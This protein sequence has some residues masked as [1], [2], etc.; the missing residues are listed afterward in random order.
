[1]SDAGKPSQ[2]IIAS[3]DIYPT[4]LEL[5]KL[6][7]PEHLDGRS[8]AAQISEPEA[9]TTAPALGF[10][11]GGNAFS[12]RTDRYRLIRQGKSNFQLYDHENDPG[13]KTNIAADHPQVVE[14]L[15]E[16]L[17]SYLKRRKALP[18]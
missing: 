14:Q 16:Q 6:P 7:V 2:A 5:A 3:V 9:V 11:G 4:L 17:E 15:N 12:M 8:F 1:M 18:E 13:E 10:W